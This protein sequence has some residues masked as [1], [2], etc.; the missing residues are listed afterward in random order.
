MSAIERQSSPSGAPASVSAARKLQAGFAIALLLTCGALALAYATTVELVAGNRQATR[1]EG[2]LTEL[3]GILAGLNNVEESRLA[4]VTAGAAMHNLR[5][6]RSHEPACGVCHSAYTRPIETEHFRQTHVAMIAELG[7]HVHGL[8]A[9]IASEPSQQPNLAALQSLIERK[10]AL[11]RED[12][13]AEKFGGFTA[14][15]SELLKQSSDLTRQIQINASAILKAANR[16]LARRLLE[17]TAW[18]RNEI[19]AVSLLGLFTLGAAIG[20]YLVV[21]RDLARRQT[22]E[23]ELRKSLAVKE[24]LLQ[25]VHHRVKNNLQVICSLLSLQTGASGDEN[26]RGVL[27]EAED[28]VRSMALVHEKLYRSGDPVNIDFSDYIQTVSDRLL[29]AYGSELR[30]I[31][32]T[33]SPSQVYLDLDRAMLCGIIVNELVTNALRHA[34]SDEGKGEVAIALQPGEGRLQLSVRDNGVGMAPE[35]ASHSAP[36]LGLR[37]VHMLTK[38]LKGTLETRSGSGTEVIITFPQVAG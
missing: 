24:T 13:P 35:A 10:I 28:R 2:A 36:T 25:E 14:Q 20:A 38:Q 19:A 17:R 7:Q 30:D 26:A 9:L 18:V 32:V 33:T 34:F 21:R 23:D 8:R 31:R 11:A 16:D 27:R 29:R 15:R 1:A 6:E 37:L 3:Q 4:W 5:V 22:L 12:I